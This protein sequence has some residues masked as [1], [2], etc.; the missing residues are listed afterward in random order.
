[1]VAT[2]FTIKTESSLLKAL[3]YYYYIV[4]VAW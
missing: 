1:M 3:N 4:T 2:Y